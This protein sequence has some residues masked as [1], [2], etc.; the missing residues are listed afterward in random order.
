MRIDPRGRIV[1][2]VLLAT[3]VL[4]GIGWASAGRTDDGPG[5][6][7]EQIAS[8]GPIPSDRSVGSTPDA[9]AAAMPTTPVAT[10][11][12]PAPAITTPATTPA[13]VTT[14]TTQARATTTTQAPAAAPTVASAGWGNLGQSVQQQLLGMVNAK[15]AAGATCGGTAYPPVPALSLDATIVKASDA[16]A[17]DMATHG[18][19]SHTGRDGSDPGQRLS[20]AGYR[21]SA[22]AE[23]IAV[24]QATPEAVVAGWFGSTGHCTNFMRSEVTEVGFGMVDNPASAYRYYWVADLSRPA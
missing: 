3:C 8:V 7:A 6:E 16:Y 24:G 9:S 5:R 15:R 17:A 12:P 23:N 18:Y 10:T 20:A 1:G 14:P 22:W 11:L 19:F 4:G 13:P 2:L 21:W